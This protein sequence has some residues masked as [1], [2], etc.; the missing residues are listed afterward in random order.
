MANPDGYPGAYFDFDRCQANSVQK[1]LYH[2][3]LPC[4]S[5]YR[6][7]QLVKVISL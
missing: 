6:E 3:P 1:Y 5:Y 2:P 4:R 7:I